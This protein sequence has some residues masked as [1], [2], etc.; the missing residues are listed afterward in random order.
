MRGWQWAVAPDDALALMYPMGGGTGVLRGS[1][2]L[3]GA[4]PSKLFGG[5]P[6]PCTI[7]RWESGDI[8]LSCTSDAEGHAVVSSTAA[9]GWTAEVD[10]VETPWLTAD[11]LR[12]AVAVGSGTHRVRWRYAAP[13]LGLGLAIAGVGI[14]L[15]LALGIASRRLTG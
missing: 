15:L 8:M 13:G 11:V 3:R 12:R 7:E 4:G 5:P 14:A 10:D 2:V 9:P 1:T 6:L